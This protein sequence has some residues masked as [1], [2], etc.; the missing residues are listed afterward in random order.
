MEKEKACSQKHEG[1]A[2]AVF[3][4]VQSLV[5]IINPQNIRLIGLDFTETIFMEIQEKL[6][7]EIPQEHLP[8]MHFDRN[9]HDS[10]IEGLHHLAVG[11]I[12]SGV[13]L[14]NT[15]QDY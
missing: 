5:A 4:T 2:D 13:R 1:F 15:K 3:K 12:F 10:L 6:R 8:V 9:L 7:N 11:E 14:I